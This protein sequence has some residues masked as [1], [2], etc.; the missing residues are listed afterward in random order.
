MKRNSVAIVGA[1][2]TS[3]LGTVSTVSRLELHIDAARNALADCG[4]TAD[5]I[6]GVATTGIVSHVAHY[7][8]I[9]PTWVDATAV[10]G[11]SFMLHVRPAAAAVNEGLCNTVL[12]THGESG[13]CRVGV[14]GQSPDPASFAGQ[15]E[16]PFDPAGP[17]SMF[18]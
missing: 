5:D 18:T 8:G 15:F 14:G 3:Q 2:E 9:V 1:S 11:C 6:D 4:L 17:P 12:I 10:G 13:R 7:L 16:A